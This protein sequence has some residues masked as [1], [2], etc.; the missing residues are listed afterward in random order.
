[1]FLDYFDIFLNK[2]YLKKYYFDIF[3]IKNTLKNNQKYT[4]QKLPK[5]IFLKYHT[6]GTAVV[7]QTITPNSNL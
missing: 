1:V 7:L 4:F 5:D 2:K 6:V 3:L